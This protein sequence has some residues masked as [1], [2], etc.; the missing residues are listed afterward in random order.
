MLQGMSNFVGSM[1]SCVAIGASLSRSMVLRG[2]GGKTQFTG[3]IAAG[4]IVIVLL[5]IADFFEPLP[6]VNCKIY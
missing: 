6:K 5:W 4:I 1:F 2:V 3:L